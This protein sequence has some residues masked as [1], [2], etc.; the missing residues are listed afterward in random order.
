MTRR[1]TLRLYAVVAVVALLGAACG[2]GDD[3]EDEEAGTTTTSTTAE[4]ASSTT[5]AEGGAGGGEQ[6][7][8]NKVTI[9]MKDYAFDVSGSIRAGT[10]TIVMKNS[11]VELHMTGFGLLRDGKTLADVRKALESE[12]EAAFE[13]VFERELDAPGGLLSPGQSMELTTPFLTKGT[14][15]LMCFVPTVGDG[16]PHTAKGMVNVLEVGE[17]DVDLSPEPDARYTVGDGKI[18]GPATLPAGEVTIEMNSGGQGPHEFLVARKRAPTTTFEEVDEAFNALFSGE[19]PP[20]PGYTDTLPAV[21]V[22]NTFDVVAG[23]T[24][25]MTLNLTA[26]DYFIG[27]AREPDEE[28]EGAEAH[29]GEL[30]E[31]KVT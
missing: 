26:G 24:V 15:A 25:H 27:C 19:V 1:R 23:K 12:D 4:A 3:E 17:G 18:E 21:M 6:N 13:A 10:S 28:G 14:Y 9:D 30:L 2:G 8:A 29:T 31:V 16:V 5:A 7:A 11:G 20:A 22:G